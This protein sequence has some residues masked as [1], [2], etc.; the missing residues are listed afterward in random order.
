MKPLAMM[1]DVESMGLYGMPISVGAVVIDLLTGE[2]MSEFY[3]GMRLPELHDVLEDD[4][5]VLQHVVPAHRKTHSTLRALYADFWSYLQNWRSQADMWAH[6]QYPVESH[7]L[8]A[9]V[10]NENYSMERI[11]TAPYPL[12]DLATYL[13]A[14]GFDPTAAFSRLDTELPAHHPLNDARQSARILYEVKNGLRVAT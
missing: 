7:F 11:G 2:V 3:A 4:K 5:W 13:W 14:H 10:R 8:R 6:C 9:C 12:F 1:I